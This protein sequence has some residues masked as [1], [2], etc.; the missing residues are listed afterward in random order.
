[1]NPSL[2]KSNS[3]LYDKTIILVLEQRNL[4]AYLEHGIPCVKDLKN[5]KMERHVLHLE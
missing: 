3:M 5:T 4:K 2:K 1:M